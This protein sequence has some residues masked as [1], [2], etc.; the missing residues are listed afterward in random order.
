MKNEI[1]I[2]DEIISNK[3][4]VIRNFK[5]MLDKDLAELYDVE[6]KYL[7]R[8]VRRNLERFPL[9]FMFELTQKENQEL[10]SQIGTLK[11]GTHT[12]YL[13]FAFTEHGIL[14]LS[15]VLNSD[16]AIKMSLQII[17]TFVQLRKLATNYEELLTKIQQIESQYNN[18]FSEI[19]EVLQKLLEKPKEIQR[20]KI[21]FK[22][23]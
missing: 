12:K 6:T 1:V 21:G 13:P 17:D 14:M 8:Q 7:K 15:S 16:N 9:N 11:Q 18:Q 22:N 23:N 3:I 20:T 2:P 4:Y 10:R 19:Y 5:V